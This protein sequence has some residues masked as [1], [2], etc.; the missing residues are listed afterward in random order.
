MLWFLMKDT[1]PNEN[2]DDFGGGHDNNDYGLWVL[3][4]FYSTERSLS[5]IICAADININ[6]YGH[7]AKQTVPLA[8]IQWFTLETRMNFWL[9]FI[10]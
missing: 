1:F 2:G 8:L 7:I 9:C 3:Q 6:K 10:I 4:E 5:F